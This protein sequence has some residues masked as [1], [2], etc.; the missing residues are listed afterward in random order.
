MA[1]TVVSPSPTSEY[2]MKPLPNRW[3]II[4]EGDSECAY[5][6]Q[7][8][9]LLLASGV[10]ENF[11]AIPVGGGD[12]KLIL[13]ACKANKYTS[14]LPFFKVMLDYDRYKR[15]DRD[16]NKRYEAAKKKIKLPD[17]LFQHHTFEDFL[18][19]HCSVDIVRAWQVFAKAHFF[20]TPLTKGPYIERLKAF[21]QQHPG[22][23]AW[24]T[25]YKKGE[26]PF[27]ELTLDHLRNLFA[28]NTTAA[29]PPYSDFATFLKTLLSPYNLF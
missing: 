2:A 14:R 25:S 24:V 15:N 22:E 7:L 16:C 13:G 18:L 26:F 21:A 5:V 11:Q 28:N 9:R 4:C 29:L 10:Q 8:C 23:L 6:N 20:N 17:F 1:F 12:F 27:S 19:M 3:T